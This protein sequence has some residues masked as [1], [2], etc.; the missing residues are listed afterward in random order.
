V[1]ICQRGGHKIRYKDLVKEPGTGLLVDKRWSD[2]RWNAVD[3]PL[4]N[5]P[6]NLNDGAP[7][8]NATGETDKEKQ[9]TIGT[10]VEVSLPGG[11]GLE[12]EEVYPSVTVINILD[13]N[14]MVLL[15]ETSVTITG[16]FNRLFFNSYRYIN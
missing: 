14:G 7:L 9:S 4:N 12:V 5:P 15:D 16:E 10:L 3:H 2:G 11:I 8:R 1:A 6:K 13:N